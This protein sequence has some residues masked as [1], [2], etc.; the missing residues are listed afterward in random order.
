MIEI[1]ITLSVQAM[2][3]AVVGEVKKEISEIPLKIAEQLVASWDEDGKL[4]LDKVWDWIRFAEDASDARDAVKDI[5]DLSKSK[6]G[7]DWTWD[8]LKLVSAVGVTGKNLSN[9]MNESRFVESTERND[10]GMPIRSH[11]SHIVGEPE[12]ERRRPSKPAR[13]PTAS[14]P[15]KK[16][17]KATQPRIT[18]IRPRKV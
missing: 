5:L 12:P 9:I 17:P 1:L 3:A 18:I 13:K 2:A 8:M 7:E 11:I 6:G 10:R 16:G 4:P 15:R 14:R